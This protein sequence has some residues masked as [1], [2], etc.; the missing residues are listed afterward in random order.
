MLN[1]KG[2]SP[3]VIVVCVLALLGLGFYAGMISQKTPVSNVKDLLNSPQPSPN[4][5][6][7]SKPSLEKR[8]T[9]C[10]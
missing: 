1:Q 9:P 7:T 6:A 2:F 10:R 4:V 8:V 5:E 3:L